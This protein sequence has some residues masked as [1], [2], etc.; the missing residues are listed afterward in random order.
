MCRYRPEDQ[1]QLWDYGS[2]SLVQTLDWPGNP[3][4]GQPGTT[5]MLYAAQFSADGK[6]LAAGGT[7]RNGEMPVAAACTFRLPRPSAALPPSS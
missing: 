4:P 2:G 1:L 5:T 6:R 3:D 7:G